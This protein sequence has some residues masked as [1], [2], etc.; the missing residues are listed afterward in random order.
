MEGEQEQEERVRA[1]IAEHGW[2]VALVPPERETPGWAHT[3]GLVE[4][5]EHPEILVFGT[6]LQLLHRLLNQLG[7]RIHAGDRF[8]VE[9]E[10]AGILE[11][12]AIA[13]QP[14][15]AKWYGAFLGNAAWHYRSEDFPVVQCFWPDSAGRFP[16]QSDCLAE[17]RAQQPQLFL[18]ETHRALSETLIEVLRTER[19]L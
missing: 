11:G 8:G 18:K 5:F 15:A 19:A 4:G 2:H 6:E 1:D 14:V 12:F 16:W 9:S 13:F 10:H 17:V 3:I 7:A